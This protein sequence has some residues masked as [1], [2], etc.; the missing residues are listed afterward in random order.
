MRIACTKNYPF[1]TGGAPARPMKALLYALLCADTHKVRLR[2]E[3]LWM[4]RNRASPVHEIDGTHLLLR[5]VDL[6]ATEVS[7]RDV[8]Y[9]VVSL[10]HGCSGVVISTW[11]K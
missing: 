5:D 7:Q 6:P 2:S 9:A 8:S 3:S 4:A 10:A 11:L 1:N